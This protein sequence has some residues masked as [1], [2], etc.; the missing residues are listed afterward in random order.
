MAGMHAT[1][2]N[3]INN[4]DC[5]LKALGKVLFRPKKTDSFLISKQKHD[6]VEGTHLKCPNIIS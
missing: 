6:Y 1:C 3:A 2:H 5:I 4:L